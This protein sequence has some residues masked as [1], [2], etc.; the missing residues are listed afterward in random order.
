M[1]LIFSERHRIV[2]PVKICFAA[3]FVLLVCFETGLAQK[4]P[5]VPLEQEFIKVLKYR[6]AFSIGAA[7]PR[8][9]LSEAFGVATLVELEIG[10]HIR[11]YV[12]IE[13]GVGYT[14]G[15]LPGEGTVGFDTFSGRIVELRGNYL[16]LPIGLKFVKGFKENDVNLSL[17][18]GVLYNRYAQS[19]SLSDLF[20]TVSSTTES[21]WGGGFYLSTTYEYF[22]AERYGLSVRGRYVMVQTSGENVGNV[23][24]QPAGEYDPETKGKTNDAWLF[25]AGALAYRF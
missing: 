20:G 24:Q 19:L 16:S 9:D 13:G 11:E 2:P 1:L 8:R 23:L 22:F 3:V 14:T 6:M 4:R 12:R 17:G 25:I 15:F 7:I 5:V 18:A 10:Y 21:R